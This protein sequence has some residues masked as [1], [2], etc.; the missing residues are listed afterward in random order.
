MKIEGF[1]L[2]IISVKDWS[3]ECHIIPHRPT[4]EKRMPFNDLKRMTLT[5]EK[6]KT[7][8]QRTLPNDERLFRGLNVH[9]TDRPTNVAHTQAYALV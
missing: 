3:Q 9:E 8:N 5:K 2:I 4:H 6:N 1:R 7:H